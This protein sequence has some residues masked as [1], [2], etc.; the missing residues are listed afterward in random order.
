MGNQEL[1][2]QPAPP[3]ETN[4]LAVIARAA[5]DPKVDVEKMQALLSMQLQISAKQ[6][7]TEF[8]AALARMQPKL[9]K[10]AKRGAIIVN[11]QL[12]SKYA[13]FEDVDDA[14]R[15]CLAE[16]GF[17]VVYGIGESATGVTVTAELRHVGGYVKRESLTLPIDNGG[18]KSAV[19]SHGS[20]IAYARRY[21]LVL[22]TNV[23]ITDEDNDGQDKEPITQDQ[24]N[25][26]LDLLQATNSSEK[27]LVQW[28]GVERLE[29]IPKSSYAKV[30]AGLEAKL[31]GKK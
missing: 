6:A 31:G 14:V 29:D 23:L 28:A 12:R 1:T 24:V 15:P 18:A 16:E 2:P 25:K 21:L 5:A 30:V 20:T 11:N 26:I 8:N 9:P 22:L 10:V 3:Q 13:R 4:F 17:S 19:Q 7:E 27:K